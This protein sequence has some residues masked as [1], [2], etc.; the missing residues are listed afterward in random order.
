M[1]FVLIVLNSIVKQYYGCLEVFRDIPDK[2]KKIGLVY[3]LY[4]SSSSKLNQFY[5]L[6]TNYVSGA[7]LFFSPAQ[8]LLFNRFCSILTLH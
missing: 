2:S 4:I 1:K 7:S 8:M 6:K 5:L 3:P